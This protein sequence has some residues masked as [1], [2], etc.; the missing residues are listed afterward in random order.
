M[1]EKRVFY[2]L[3][4][5]TALLVALATLT[6]RPSMQSESLLLRA[7]LGGSHISTTQ[8]RGGMGLPL[9]SA[10]FQVSAR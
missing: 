5:I 4:E 10:R 7:T 3:A 1:C 8:T 6:I 9:Y 2:M